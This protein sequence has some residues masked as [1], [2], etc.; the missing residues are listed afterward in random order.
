MLCLRH[1]GLDHTNATHCRI[2]LTIYTKCTRERR[3][4]STTGGHWEVLGFQ[5]CGR[6][7]SRYKALDNAR[8]CG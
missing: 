6:G 3:S 7:Q 8:D 4:V 1:I 5:V 2:L